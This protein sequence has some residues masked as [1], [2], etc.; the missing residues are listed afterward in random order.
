MSTLEADRLYA[1]LPAVYRIR[2]EQ[3]GY[4]LRD[5]VGLIAREFAALE[6][7]IEQLYDDQFIE[8][9]ED[10]VA[11]YIGDLIGCRP[12]RGVWRSGANA[13][14]APDVPV[15]GWWRPARSSRWRCCRR[16]QQSRPRGCKRR[17]LP[18]CWRIREN[19]ICRRCR[20]S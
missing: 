4:P 1:L 7:N 15:T 8:T 3:Q 2:D 12:R 18:N 16:L 9:C 20:C 19:S 5:L 6:E 11:P 10:W 14:V 17:C 13:A